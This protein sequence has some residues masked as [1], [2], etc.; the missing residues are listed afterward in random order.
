MLEITIDQQVIVITED[1]LDEFAQDVVAQHFAD[2][3]QHADDADLGD[4][5]FDRI[6]F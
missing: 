6:G 2:E 4:W 1:N 3:G 5:L